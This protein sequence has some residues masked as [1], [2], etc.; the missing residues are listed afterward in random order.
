[1]SQE[2]ES[3]QLFAIQPNDN[4]GFLTGVRADGTQVLAGGFY[5][6]M[7]AYFFDAQGAICG[8]TRQEWKH[9]S[10]VDPATGVL[11][12]LPPSED[13]ENEQRFSAWLRQLDFVPGPIRVQ[14]FG[15]DE[16]CTGIEALPSWLDD[17]DEQTPEERADTQRMRDQWVKG[18]Y[19]VFFWNNDFHMKADGTVA[20]S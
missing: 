11:R 8:G 14:A 12:P 13:E 6:H 9:T 10:S 1:M 16:Y 4:Y 3:P 20:S 15:D 18:G 2:T 17:T 5:P 19:F 7:V